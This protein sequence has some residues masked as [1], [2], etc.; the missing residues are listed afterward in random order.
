MIDHYQEE[1]QVSDLNLSHNMQ[2]TNSSKVI[3]REPS[4]KLFYFLFR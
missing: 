4:A 3:Q 1:N 2:T